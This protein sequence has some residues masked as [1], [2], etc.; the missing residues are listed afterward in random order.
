MNLILIAMKSKNLR[1]KIFYVSSRFNTNRQVTHS[2]LDPMEE[3]EEVSQPSGSDESFLRMRS[4]KWSRALRSK[5]TELVFH[6]DGNF[7]FFWLMVLSLTVEYNL[8]IQI[9][10]Q[11][12]PSVQ[13][14]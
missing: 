11:A 4:K 2:L 5:C 3:M 6:P 12:F 1:N 13:V 9:L 14:R 8:W 10:R 7:L